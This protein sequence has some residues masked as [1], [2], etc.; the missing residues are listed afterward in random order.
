MGT[1]L[2]LEAVNGES[3]MPSSRVYV[4]L[5]R[6]AL[7]VQRWAA[8]LPGRVSLARRILQGFLLATRLA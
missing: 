8:L 1:S 3:I 4:L 7:I 6:V 5:G 2:K